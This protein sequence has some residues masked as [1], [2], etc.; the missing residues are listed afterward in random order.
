MDDITK[1]TRLLTSPEAAAYLSR[2]PQTL[3]LWRV[4][5]FGPRYIRM[6]NAPY[7]RV[8]YRTQDLEEWL[9]ART[10]RNTTQETVEEAVGKCSRKP[11]PI[12]D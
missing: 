2:Q 3:R 4:R 1:S 5:G 9:A 12:N 6:G 11:R 7:A 8:A 10:F